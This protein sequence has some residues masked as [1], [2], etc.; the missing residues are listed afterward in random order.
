[1]YIYKYSSVNTRNLLLLFFFYKIN[2]TFINMVLLLLCVYFKDECVTV[3]TKL[4]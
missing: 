2:I 3:Y 4:I 1:M